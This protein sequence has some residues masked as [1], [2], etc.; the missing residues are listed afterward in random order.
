MSYVA[1]WFALAA[2]IKGLQGAGELYARFQSYH[3]EDT[4]GSGRLLRAECGLFVAALADFRQEFR[5]VLSPKWC[6]AW[7]GF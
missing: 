5:D 7:I 4:Y 3:Q 1:R 2:R 6:K